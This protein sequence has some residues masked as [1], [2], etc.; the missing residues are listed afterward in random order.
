M[1]EAQAIDLSR[2]PIFVLGMHRSGTSCL[3]ALLQA[4]GAVLP[5]PVIRNWDNPHGHHEA[6]SLL[7]LNEDVLATSGGH[8]LRAPETLRWTPEQAALRDQLL[9]LRPAGGPALWKD[10][11]S[12]LTWPFWQA[13]PLPL[14]A[15]GVIRHPLAVA[16]S[17]LA[18]RSMP[19]EEGLRLW[20]AH[21]EVLATLELPI[22]DFDAPADEFVYAVTD[23]ARQMGLQAEPDILRAAYR[24]EERHHHR[25]PGPSASPEL[26]AACETLYG[27]LGGRP[28]SSST[29]FPWD[30]IEAA[31]AALARGDRGEAREQA[32]LALA[33]A[34]EAALPALC[35]AF[36]RRHAG[37]ALLD[38]LPT[39]SPSVEL[40]RGKC[41]LDAG[42]AAEAVPV[43]RA[44]AELYEARHLLPVA[45][46]ESG[47]AEA[48]DRELEKLLSESLYPFRV[49][50][51]RAEWAWL[52]GQVDRARQHL[53]AALEA[54]PPWRKGRLLHRRAEW[55]EQQGETDAAAQDRAQAAVIDPGYRR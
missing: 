55:R 53:D 44:A 3:A 8:W 38:V 41:L 47:E 20:R 45:L 33:E 18:W 27:Q 29:P 50:A 6:L 14:R 11:R 12:L 31:R 24:S 48:A 26:L 1:L 46:W 7:R 35:M 30:A 21:V 23:I 2:A 51:R 52:R 15:I 25:G 40:V 19:L 5:G 9:S 32:R 42:R 28:S 13:G 10:P 54:A 34:P 37:A 39:S 16:R 4:A 36:L 49:H 43:L 22:L 17:L